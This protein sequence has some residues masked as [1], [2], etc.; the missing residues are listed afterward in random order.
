MKVSL[1]SKKKKSSEDSHEAMRVQMLERRE[2]SC[3]ETEFF[4]L[5]GIATFF[6]VR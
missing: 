1:C 5:F 6:L 4:C 3:N 2:H